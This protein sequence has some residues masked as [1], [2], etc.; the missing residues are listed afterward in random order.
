MD[1]G[2]T[3]DF[4][5]TFSK[6]RRRTWYPKLGKKMNDTERSCDLEITEVDAA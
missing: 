3:I 1:L 2:P 4:K 6:G 5:A